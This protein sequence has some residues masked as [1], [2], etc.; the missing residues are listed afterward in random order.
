MPVIKLSKEG[1]IFIEYTSHKN[2]LL[3]LFR[4]YGMEEC[5]YMISMKQL[6]FSMR[7]MIFPSVTQVTQKKKIPVFQKA[8]LDGMIFAYDYRAGLACVMTSQQILLC[9]LDPLHSYDTLRMS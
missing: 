6:G 2:S 3:Q 5:Q 4:W 7:K 9:K 8:D 1:K